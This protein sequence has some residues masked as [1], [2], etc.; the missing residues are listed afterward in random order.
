MM[1]TQQATQLPGHDTLLARDPQQLPWAPW[2]M[3][4]AYFKLLSTDAASGRFALMLKL[5]KG[6]VAPSHRHIG[7]VEGLVLEGGF[8]YTDAPQI[9]FTA[10]TYLLERDGAVHQPVSP[11][12]AVMFAVFQGPVEGLDG[13]GRITG[14]ID[15]K[16]H[17]K[18]WD[19]FMA[20]RPD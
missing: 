18:T 10:G 14:R 8:H 11:E 4:G 2:A 12:G 15:W 20:A 9:R 7:A 5:E 17:V 16:W 3:K 6:F 19:A 13:E 1:Q